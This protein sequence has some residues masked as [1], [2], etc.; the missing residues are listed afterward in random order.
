M[1]QTIEV[2]Y[3]GNV[4][5]PLMPVEGLQEHE[6]AVAILWP[7]TPKKNLRKLA[8]MLPRED[9]KAMRKFIDKEFEWTDKED[10][11]R[12]IKDL[13]A[14][15]SIQGVPVGVDVLQQRMSEADLIPNELSRAIVEA[16]EE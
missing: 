3:E 12:W 11:K 14:D 10:Q 7:R 2:I 8:G 15:L 6:R 1:P 4:L 13:F 5:K 9:S 16:R